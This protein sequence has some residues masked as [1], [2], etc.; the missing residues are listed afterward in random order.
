M[1]TDVIGPYRVIETIG[2]GTFGIVYQAYQPF[3]DRYVAV[4]MLH[5]DFGPRSDSE[6]RFMDEARAIARLRHPNIVTVYEF[7]TVVGE[8]I[9]QP[10][11]VMEHL[12]GKTLQD[13]MKSET[14]PSL[15]IAAIT[16]QLAQA[17]DYAHAHGVIHRDLKPAN[18]LFSDSDQPVIVDFGLA[19]LVQQQ[20]PAENAASDHYLDKL[21]RGND[22]TT[23]STIS[24][25]PAYMAPEQ[26]TGQP[27]GPSTDQYALAVIVYELLSQ[28]RLFG[29]LDTSTKLL[30]RMEAVNTPME[31][32][33]PTPMP[34]VE[35]VLRRALAVNPADRFGS[36]NAFARALAEAL[37]PDRQVTRSVLVSDPVQVTQLRLIRQTITGFLWGI[38]AIVI[39]VMLFSALLYFRGYVS[40]I[41]TLFVWDGII[42]R[43]QPNTG[44]NVV[45]GIW[46]DSAA[47]R[48]GYQLGD[49]FKTD[50]LTEYTDLGGDYTVNGMSRAL[51]PTSW[52]PHLG[53]VITRTIMRSG[54]PIT[55]SY[56]IDRSWHALLL[57]VIYGIPAILAC[58]SA[59]WLLRRWG[60]EPGVRI[61]FPLLLSSGFLFLTQ[62]LARLIPYMDTV[63]AH[64]VLPSLLLF[65][66]LFPEPLPI[67]T[68]RRW[69]VWLLYIPLLGPLFEFLVGTGIPIGGG[70]ELQFV[71]YIG[72][73]LALIPTLILKW[74]WRDLK[75][76]RRLRG[77]IVAFLF[78][79]LTV[80]PSTVINVLD[81]N[82]SRAVFGSDVG[83]R[84]AAYFVVSLG[85]AVGILLTWHGYHQLQTQIGP[86]FI[87]KDK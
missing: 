78:V 57:L 31:V 34:A 3:L 43:Q 86:S 32:R 74:G 44:L 17:L 21:D 59:A 50:L 28:K 9:T 80:V 33:L 73:A 66:L 76:Y 24:G 45:T 83:V 40:G 61:I 81:L 20:M 22:T 11:L 47:Q 77:L 68:R 38:A 67:L 84:L 8:Q 39:L 72:Y 51:L 42:T 64:I 13:R 87:M 65:I 5:F 41:N 85:S 62:A 1:N 37:L 56:T 15:Q 10:Y 52:T 79:P 4:K 55:L 60:P 35:A 75:H 71:T 7:G 25:T 46:P 58:L 23:D 48:V 6:Q 69:L 53:D 14:L 26:I 27:T 49:I 18:I 36:A 54:Q 19:Q 12:P 29:E 16:E 70:L 30:H 63:A 2:K 82:T